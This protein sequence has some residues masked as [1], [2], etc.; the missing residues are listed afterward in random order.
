MRPIPPARGPARSAATWPK[1]PAARTRL[2]M[3]SPRITCSALKRCCRTARVIEIGG[4][5]LDLPGYDL[6]GLLTGS[7]GTMALVTKVTVR[8]MRQ[9]E[10]VKTMLAIYNDVGPGRR[11]RGCADGARHHAGGARDARRSDAAAWWKRQ[12]TPVIRWMRRRFC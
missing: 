5:A 1:T 9:P 8:L 4:K 6:T 10:A 11:H 2:P 3:A 7:E 12:R